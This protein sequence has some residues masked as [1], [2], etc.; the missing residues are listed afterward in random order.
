M[1]SSPSVPLVIAF[2]LFSFIV[3]SPMIKKTELFLYIL[4]KKVWTVLISTSGLLMGKLLVV[5]SGLS[6][7]TARRLRV[8]KLWKDLSG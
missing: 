2:S 6:P 1:S 8:T 4:K 3:A 5:G 7:Q